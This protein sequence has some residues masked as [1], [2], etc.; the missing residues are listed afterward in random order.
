MRSLYLLFS[1]I[2]FSSCFDCNKYY[3]SKFRQIE[4]SGIIDSVYID[5]KNRYAETILLKGKNKYNGMI[6]DKEILGLFEHSEKGDSIYKA[7]GSLA[8]YLYKSDT[9]IV[10]YPVCNGDTLK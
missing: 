10:F 6:G 5:K 9:T 4:I 1:V 2:L 7:K 8:V 3:D